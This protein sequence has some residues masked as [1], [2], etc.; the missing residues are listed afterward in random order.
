M[1]AVSRTL[2]LDRP[3][4][5]L[6][7]DELQHA[8]DAIVRWAFTQHETL[9]SQSVGNTAEPAEL[10]PLLDLPAPDRPIPFEDIFRCFNN[11]VAGHALRLNHPRFL[12]FV[13]G[14]PS[15]PSILGDW[16]TAAANFFGGVW[17]EAAGPTQVELTV[18]NWFKDW[19]GFPPSAEGLLTSGGSEANL[20]ALVV[21]RDAVPP[22]E[23]SRHVLYVGEQRHWSIDRAARIV[24]LLPQQICVIPGADDV[25]THADA[26]M[27]AIAADREAGLLPWA[28]VANA[29]ATN[30][31]SVDPLDE[32]AEV[33]RREKLWLH[34]DAA[35]G[36]AA[37]LTDEGKQKLRGIER[38]D[39]ITFDPH[40]WFA[41]TF[42][43]GGLLVRRGGVLA[44]SFAMRPDYLQDTAP[45][46]DEINVADRGVA[47]TRRFRALKIWLSVQMLGLDWYRDLA[48]RCLRLAEYAEVKLRE[49]GF[50]IVHPRQLS[51]VCFRWVP[52][53]PEK[54]DEVNRRIVHELLEG[55][56]AFLSSTMLFGKVTL[57]ICFINWRTTTA[58]VDQVIALMRA[59]VTDG[60][61]ESTFLTSS[62]PLQGRGPG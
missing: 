47:L 37:I 62:P 13:P 59:V 57:R 36:W 4:D 30:T 2:S 44:D 18:I 21:A 19:L 40:K 10:K 51:I 49:A 29:G 42:E 35:Y 52:D 1:I 31:G 39:S 15:F 56:Q 61:V 50:E 55:G 46:H 58:D 53:D 34:V 24:G 11:H 9:S 3:L 26:L 43:A 38:A 20:T 25:C 12:A 6:T 5:Q 60:Q 8:A 14:A 22:E 7:P 28:F 48:E 23:R 16:L 27:D 33:C 41:Q 17:L 54:A 32:L 45:E